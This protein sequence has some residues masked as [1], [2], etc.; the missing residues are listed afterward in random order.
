MGPSRF[1]LLEVDMLTPCQRCGNATLRTWCD[2]CIDGAMV[3]ITRKEAN[4]IINRL[5]LSSDKEASLA[6]KLRFAFTDNL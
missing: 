3:R 4:L 1:S 5:W 6:E 2:W